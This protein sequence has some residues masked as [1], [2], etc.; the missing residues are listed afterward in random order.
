MKTETPTMKT[1]NEVC[2]SS[3]R[4]RTGK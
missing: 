3:C 1:L 2:R 4:T